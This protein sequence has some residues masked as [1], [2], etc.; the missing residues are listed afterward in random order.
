MDKIAERTGLAQTGQK[1]II[2]AP[3]NIIPQTPF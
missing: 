3:K 1:R 2:A